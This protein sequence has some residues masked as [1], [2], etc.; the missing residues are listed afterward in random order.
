LS[1]RKSRD[2]AMK[3]AVAAGLALLASGCGYDYL[4]RSDRIA[5]VAGDA[6]KANLEGETIDPSK[7]SMYVTSGLG[8]D[9]PKKSLTA[10]KTSSGNGA[11]SDSVPGAAAN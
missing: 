7:G 3:A 1:A 2:T 8:K 4:Q 5:Y 9:G 11:G 6:V 10:D